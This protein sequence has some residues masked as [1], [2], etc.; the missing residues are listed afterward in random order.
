MEDFGLCYKQHVML[1]NPKGLGEVDYMYSS[2]NNVVPD[3]MN[4]Q[5]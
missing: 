5:F 4:Y 3:S 1:V 2:F